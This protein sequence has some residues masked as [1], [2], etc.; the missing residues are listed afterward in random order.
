[1]KKFYTLILLAVLAATP[2][3]AQ[4]YFAE[5]ELAAQ[6]NF[7]PSAKCMELMQKEN[8]PSYYCDCSENF[9]R[10]RE[11]PNTVVTDT[12]W[13]KTSAGL[14]LDG[15]SAFLFSENSLDMILMLQCQNKQ[16]DG[17]FR[18]YTVDSNQSMNVT[19]NEIKEKLENNGT[20]VSN[21]TVIY[22]CIAPSV[23]GTESRFICKPY[24]EGPQS[25][26]DDCLPL[27]RDMELVSSD[28]V[29]VYALT[30]AE[31]PAVNGLQVEWYQTDYPAMLTIRKGDCASGDVVASTMIMPGVPY[32]LPSELLS[33]MRGGE[34]NLY[35]EFRATGAAARLRLTE[36]KSP[37]TGCENVGAPATDAHLVMQNGM[38][39]IL[40]DGVR[41]SLTGARF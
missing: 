33:E 19:S 5:A 6:D 4:G 21:N 27:I 14:F 35:L 29:N 36:V 30:P 39:Y 12:I 34:E 15:C 37:A 40:R 28:M 8:Y 11:L 32:A 7:T 18:R 22:V 25:T 16:G 20:S 24:N 1:M 26:C 38:I 13:Y 2:A 17:T 41:Y 23:P 10:L 3:L 31:I 9:V